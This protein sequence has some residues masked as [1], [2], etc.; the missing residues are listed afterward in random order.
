MDFPRVPMTYDGVDV[1][2]VENPRT[3]STRHL[4]SFIVLKHHAFGR[5]AI[6]NIKDLIAGMDHSLPRFS[7]LQDVE[8][9]FSRG[10][11]E[12]FEEEEVR[13]FPAVFEAVERRGEASP[14][15][16]HKTLIMQ[17][18]KEHEYVGGLLKQLVG[19]SESMGEPAKG[20]FLAVQELATD[21]AIHMDLEQ[22]ELHRR[23]RMIYQLS[24]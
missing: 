1:T 24:P 17:V 3:L 22:K 12:H 16:R 14:S 7:E 13:V 18:E 11:L 20:V 19:I 8:R 10:L 2:K 15:P 4:M 23:V 5:K 21:L 6:E 9:S